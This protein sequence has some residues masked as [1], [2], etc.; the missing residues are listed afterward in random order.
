MTAI[1]F[2]SVLSS[3]QN[4]AILSYQFTVYLEITRVLP[5]I[6]HTLP[7]SEDFFLK[8][9]PV[10]AWRFIP[11]IWYPIRDRDW[12]S[13]EYTSEALPIGLTCFMYSPCLFSS[14]QEVSR[15]EICHGY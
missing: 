4:A 7:V 1:A 15:H 10:F 9:F 14:K 8:S 3:S 2:S 6:Q 13:H 5:S 12:A 11:E